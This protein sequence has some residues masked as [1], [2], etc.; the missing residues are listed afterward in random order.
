MSF[1][2]YATCIQYLDTVIKFS[3]L[4]KMKYTVG[5]YLLLTG[6]IYLLIT[7]ITEL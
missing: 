7:R 1:Y 2:V 4:L 6:R 5:E 3:S